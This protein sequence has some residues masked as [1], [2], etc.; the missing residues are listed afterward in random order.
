M[1]EVLNNP[2]FEA[3]RAVQMAQESNCRARAWNSEGGS[4]PATAQCAGGDEPEFELWV[5]TEL[6]AAW[7]LEDNDGKDAKKESWKESCQTSTVTRRWDEF[8]A[9]GEP[10]ARRRPGGKRQSVAARFAGL[11][12]RRKGPTAVEA[13][14]LRVLGLEESESW[15][16][17]EEEVRAAFKRR[18]VQCHPDKGGSADEFSAIVAAYN[19]LTGASGRR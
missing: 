17:D 3:L 12:Q 6:E 11:E 9:L 8:E 19:C 5:E 15:P 16:P 10:E 14:H 7:C 18:S 13:A 4:E 2:D 1:R